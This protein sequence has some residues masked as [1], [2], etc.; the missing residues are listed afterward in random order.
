MILVVLALGGLA[1]G[2]LDFVAPNQFRSL[3]NSLRSVLLGT[4]SQPRGSTGR[5]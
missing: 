4:P 3:V 1:L 5:A 2:A